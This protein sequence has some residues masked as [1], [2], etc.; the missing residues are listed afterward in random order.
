MRFLAEQLDHG[1][2][3]LTCSSMTSRASVASS[4]RATLSNDG[5]M[6]NKRVG[7]KHQVDRPAVG[8]DL[9]MD[10]PRSKVAF[11]GIFKAS[12]HAQVSTFSRAAGA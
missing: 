10:R 1:K 3:L 2:R 5:E 9:S 12:Q 6:G 4:N 11:V 8:R 7:L